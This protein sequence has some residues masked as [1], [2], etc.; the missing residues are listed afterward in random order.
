MLPKALCKTVDPEIVTLLA[1]L[2][3]LKFWLAMPGKVCVQLHFDCFDVWAIKL[4]LITDERA[5][6]F[7]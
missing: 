7:A 4:T 5:K 1:S 3:K 6:Y 2:D